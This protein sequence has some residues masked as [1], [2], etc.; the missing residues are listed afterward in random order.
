MA[1]PIGNAWEPQGEIY[2]RPDSTPA[3]L[4]VSVL[5]A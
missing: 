2:L 1:W 3:D 4:F 5:S